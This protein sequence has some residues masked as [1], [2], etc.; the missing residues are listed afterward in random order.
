[1]QESA[2]IDTSVIDLIETNIVDFNI[3]TVNVGS[4][5][6]QF[7]TWLLALDITELV[8]AEG[9]AIDASTFAVM[10]GGMVQSSQFSS[11]IMIM[12]TLKTIEFEAGIVI[13]AE[14]VDANIEAFVQA[15][16]SIFSFDIDVAVVEV[17][18]LIDAVEAAFAVVVGFETDITVAIFFI[19]AQFVYLVEFCILI[20][21]DFCIGPVADGLADT[22]FTT[23]AC[24][25]AADDGNGNASVSY[26][27][28]TLPT[29]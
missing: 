24:E 28:L 6:I 9:A 2:T 1:M 27:H 25:C 7:K 16:I 15:F 26:T 17:S 18:V 3:A 19:E 22:F 5:M 12:E 14:V 8:D 20:I 10:I 4:I 13:A 23:F 11:L 21:E 29:N